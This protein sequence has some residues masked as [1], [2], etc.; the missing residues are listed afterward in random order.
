MS[1]K[2]KII[3]LP[4]LSTKRTDLKSECG[5]E[6]TQD[7]KLAAVPLINTALSDVARFP[8]PLT[9]TGVSEPSHPC[10]AL[11]PTDAAGAQARAGYHCNFHGL[12]FDSSAWDL[13]IR[14]T[15]Q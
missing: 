7:P 15:C 4:L 9:H 5:D 11:L 3:R 2:K 1:S 14:I 8:G 13:H 10:R 6:G 12:Q